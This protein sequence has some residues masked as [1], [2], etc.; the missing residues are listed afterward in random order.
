MG[1]SNGT[2]SVWVRIPRIKGNARQAIQ[3]HWGKADAA[4]ESNGKAVFNES[5]GYLSVWHMTEPV[6]DEVGT[7]ESK[8]VGTTATGGMIGKA[9]H[10]AGKQGIFGGD[11]IANY[12]T[13]SSPH[14]SEA[15][16]RAEATNGHIVAWGNEQRQGK[17]IVTLASPPHV[18]MDAYFSG[19]NVTGGSTLPLADWIHVVHTYTQGEARLYI[20]GVLDGK[21][22]QGAPLAIKS[23]ARLWIG[24]W[25]NNYNFVGD[26]DEVRISK[27]ARSADWVKLQYENQKPLQTLVGPLVRAGQCVFRHPG[28]GHRVGGQER[29]HHRPGRR[30]PEGLLDAQGRRQGNRRRDRSADLHRSTPAG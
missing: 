27:V 11:K 25:Y 3:M 12:P 1:C 14:S 17:V 8:D 9:R 30:R 7:L 18:R 26:I 2:A 23:P 29:A 28:G 19:G 24:G 16:F 10:F 15:W 4:S 20:N 22:N 21:S 6:T 5:N 13:G